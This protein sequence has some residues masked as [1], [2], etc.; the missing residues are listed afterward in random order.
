VKR[1]AILGSTGSIG[2]SALRVVESNRKDFRIVALT[3]WSNVALLEKQIRVFRPQVVVVADGEA[4]ARLE[5][6][7]GKKLASSL[8][9]MAGPSG[10][11]KAAAYTAA[12][13]V[14]SSLQG[15]SS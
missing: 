7:I 6:R 1:I 15:I 11:A 2:K 5:Q 4:V 12:D 3:A 10:V 14:L 9:I 8:R 13:F